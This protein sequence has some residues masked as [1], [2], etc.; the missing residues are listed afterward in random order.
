MPSFT[1]PKEKL[2]TQLYSAKIRVPRYEDYRLARKH[3]P[4]PRYEGDP[5]AMVPYSVEELLLAMMIEEIDGK[6]YDQTP[7]DMAEKLN[8]FPI[9]DRQYL[10]SVFTSMFYLTREQAQTARDLAE[11]MAKQYKE[12]YA[13]DRNLFPS[14]KIAVAFYAPNTGAQMQADRKFQSA[15]SVYMGYSTQLGCSFE[16][17][18]TAFCLQSINGEKVDQAKDVISTFDS[19]EIAD[20]QF[21]ATLFTSMFTINENDRTDAKKLANDLKSQ[22]L[23]TGSDAPKVKSGAPKNTQSTGLE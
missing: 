23:G 16:D 13:V 21:F 18:L 12:I 11:S 8:P 5:T 10:M 19:W 7:R 9:Q 4:V 3:Y 6:P 2:P 14:S 1:I 17:Y 22:L 15:G 20:M